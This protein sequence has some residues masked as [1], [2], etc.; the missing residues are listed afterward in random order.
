MVSAEN[1]IKVLFL[2]YDVIRT[3]EHDREHVNA[4]L[5][6]YIRMGDHIYHLVHYMFAGECRSRNVQQFTKFI[7]ICGSN[8]GLECLTYPPA[9]LC[10]YLTHRCPPPHFCT[11]ATP[12]KVSLWCVITTDD[13]V[14]APYPA[15]VALPIRGKD[16]HPRCVLIYAMYDVCD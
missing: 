2:T 1:F 14:F 4:F 9:R 13:V 12:Q 6:P 8:N 5:N 11:V 16:F 3:C 7:R 10:L 15:A